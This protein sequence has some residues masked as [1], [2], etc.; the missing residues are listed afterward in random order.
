MGV[1]SGSLAN[2]KKVGSDNNDLQKVQNNVE[3]AVNPIIS[4]EI[5]DGNLIKN[6]QLRALEVIYVKHGL[7]R[8]P[9]GWIVVRKRGDVRIWD[10][11]DSNDKP[12]ST[13]ALTCSHDIVV[14]LWIF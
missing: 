8:P 9:L 6:V 7:G 3:A 4:K 1:N 12:K 5:V 13:L 10:V 11:Q 14:D 2:F